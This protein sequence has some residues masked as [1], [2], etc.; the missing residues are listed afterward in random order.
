VLGA[1][2]GWAKS[3]L[4][5]PRVRAQFRDFFHRPDTF[6]LAICN[7]CQMLST[8]RE[9]IPGAAHFPRFLQNASERFE[10]RLCMVRV[11]P[12]PS[13][14]LRGMQGSE[15]PLVVS[16]GEGRVELP[17]GLDAAAL[18]ARQL[19]DGAL[20]PGRVALRFIDHERRP[21]ERYPDNPNGSIRG[22]TGISSD[23]GRV[24]IAMPHPER[25]FRTAQLS[26]HPRNWGHY[27][28]WM[29]LFDNARA[30]I[31]GRK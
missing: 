13:L 29:R 5:E 17:S 24:L 25:V 1:G 12:S 10:A 11:E 2:Q 28:P 20:T 26:W 23:D 27:S 6:T 15:L 7:G 16:H 14:F 30:W 22:I 21:A 3:I 31:D 9:L 4:L 19:A 8:L 18:E